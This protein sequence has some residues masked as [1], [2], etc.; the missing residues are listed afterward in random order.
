[1]ENIYGIK[2]IN[3]YKFVSPVHI[4]QYLFL[5]PLYDAE[6]NTYGTDLRNNINTLFQDYNKTKDLIINDKEIQEINR[7]CENVFNKNQDYTTLLNLTGNQI[8]NIPIV[9]K[10]LSRRIYL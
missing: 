10:I 3:I 6:N 1:M 2:I 7:L 5:G 4:N 9:N 8:E